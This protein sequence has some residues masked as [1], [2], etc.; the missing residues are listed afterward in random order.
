ARVRQDGA[1]RDVL[2]SLLATGDAAAPALVTTDDGSRMT[3][4]QLGSRVEQLARQLAC[5]GVERADRVALALPNA[6]EIVELPLAI[7]AVAA[8]AAPLHPAY[9][10]DESA[11]S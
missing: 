11:F 4:G 10:H 2:A 9:T 5:A 1:V 8:A 7:A 6:P 3:Y